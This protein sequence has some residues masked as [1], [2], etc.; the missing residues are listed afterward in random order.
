MFIALCGPDFCGKTLQASRVAERLKAQNHDVLHLRFPSIDL[1]GCTARA[2]I[3]DANALGE[4]PFKPIAIQ[5]CM[6][7]DMYATQKEIKS[8]L[9]R[10]GIVLADRWAPSGLVYGAY[11][12]VP[13]DWLARAQSALLVPDLHILLTISTMEMHRRS[14]ERGGLGADRYENATCFTRV[15]EGYA[16]LWAEND[17]ARWVRVDGEQV[18]EKVTADIVAQI[19]IRL[20]VMGF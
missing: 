20:R 16:R 18:A 1:A 10:G 7:A 8:H 6:V 17:P 13:T 2:L 11:E 4:T 15:S 14:R 12:G 3:T 19:A 9:A 5:A